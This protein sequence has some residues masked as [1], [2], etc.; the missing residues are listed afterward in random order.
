MK[1]LCIGDVHIQL[2]NI[3][4]ITLFL[5]KLDQILEHEKPDLCVSLGDTMHYHE[6]VFT[7]CLCKVKEYIE[8]ITK[9]CPVYF[10]IGN[11]E[12]INN[13]DFLS[14][15]HPYQAFENLPN[16]T[17][18]DTVKQYKSPKMVLTFVPYVPP[19][20]FKEALN[21]VSDWETSHFIFAHQEFKGCKMG[22]I[23]SEEGDEWSLDLPPVI[24]GHIHD[25]QNL[26]EG[27]YYAG[28]PLQ[29]AF[30]DTENKTLMML[31][32]DEIREISL[33][34]PR[35]ITLYTNANEFESIKT[36]NK[37]KYRITVSGTKDD[38]KRVRAS[39]KYR[40]LLKSGV[41]VSFKLHKENEIKKDKRPL[42]TF[43]NVIDELIGTDTELKE[44]F[45]RVSS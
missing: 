6:K 33:D 31:D 22:A 37:H 40:D 38:F 29:H 42:K 7:R 21:T 13:S 44:L 15:I 23:T 3:P 25:K 9:W 41:K 8:T 1:I 17:I 27:V 26:P 28:T 30:G 45:L 10:L 39:L 36:D 4:E 18:V 43:I 2:S 24:S 19:G 20:R 34:L 11:H 5:E 35:K 14:N 32:N 16:V 12:R